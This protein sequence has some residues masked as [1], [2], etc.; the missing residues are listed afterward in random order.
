MTDQTNPVNWFEIPENDL[1][2]AK[3]FYETVLGLQLRTAREIEWRCI[4]RCNGPAR[5]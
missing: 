1:E 3:Q 4:R 2:R 5:Y